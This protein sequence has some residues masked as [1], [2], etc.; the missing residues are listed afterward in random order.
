MKHISDILKE[1]LIYTTGCTMSDIY[2]N[3]WKEKKIAAMRAKLEKKFRKR[4]KMM[5]SEDIDE[6]AATPGNTMDMGNVEPGKSEPLPQP[7]KKKQCKDKK[8]KGKCEDEE[9]E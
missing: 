4:H 9:E 3:Y 6:D 2:K 8:C 5:E 1:E 7:K